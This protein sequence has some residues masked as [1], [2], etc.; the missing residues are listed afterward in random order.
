[1]T[2]SFCVIRPCS[3]ANFGP[4]ERGE[5]VFFTADEV[6]M[7]ASGPNYMC[8]DPNSAGKA[9]AEGGAHNW[10]Q[11]MLQYLGGTTNSPSSTGTSSSRTAST[12]PGESRESGEGESG[13]SGVASEVQGGTQ[14]PGVTPRTRAVA[15]VD[16]GECLFEDK[17]AH[18]RRAGAEAVIVRNSEVRTLNLIHCDHQTDV[19]CTLF[20]IQ[21]A[22]FI[23]AG[24]SDVEGAEQEVKAQV[25]HEVEVGAAPVTVMLSKSDGEVFTQT[26]LAHAQ[27]QQDLGPGTDSSATVT[28][29]SKV[30]HMLLES[31]LLGSATFPKVFLQRKLILV[32]GSG[33]WATLLKATKGDDW[34]LY[35]LS[36][37][38]V[39]LTH[40]ALSPP[41]AV[42]TAGGYGKTLPHTVL[43]DPLA[44]YAHSVSRKCPSIIHSQDGRDIRV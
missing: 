42:L 4:T 7:S 19:T 2:M 25:N 38:D 10:W 30:Q 44:L 41:H 22:V 9:G 17:A 33:K 15:V 13:T 18:A 34:Q 37:E 36:R 29:A 3:V 31:E 20:Y 39:Y 11:S 21:D 32:V 12:L 40:T 24:K 16:R 35:L 43:A 27:R 8:E 14:D 6:L 1:M 26:L 5:S 28:I 23:M